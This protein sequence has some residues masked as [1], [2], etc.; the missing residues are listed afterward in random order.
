MADQKR[1]IHQCRCEDCQLDSNGTIAQEHRAINQVIAMLDERRRRLFVGML[2]T[3]WGHGGVM[4]FGQVTGL[5][6]T[7]IR[8]GQVEIE[9]GVGAAGR[10]VR[11][12]GGGRKRLEKKLRRW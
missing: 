12:A 7:T 4:L 10:R 3:Q 5:S 6:R 2:A 8:R 1:L 11:R 9:R